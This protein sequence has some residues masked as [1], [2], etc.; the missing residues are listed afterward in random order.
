MV[1]AIASA[2]NTVVEISLETTT[3][4]EDKEKCIQKSL[5]PYFQ[6]FDRRWNT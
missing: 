1:F 3:A 6:L 2:T 5:K 4:K